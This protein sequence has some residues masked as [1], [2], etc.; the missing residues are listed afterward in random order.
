MAKSRRGSSEDILL[1]LVPLLAGATSL[2]L[3]VALCIVV[4]VMVAGKPVTAVLGEFE[5]PVGSSTRSPTATPTTRTPPP[6]PAPATRTPTA[7]PPPTIRTPAPAA[8]P[9]PTPADTTPPGQVTGLVVDP[10]GGSGEIQLTWDAS[11]EPDVDHY[12]IYRSTTEGGPYETLYN[13]V[14][15]DQDPALPERIRGFLDSPAWDQYCYVVSAV[16]PSGTEG[17]LSDE[18]CSPSPDTPTP[19]PPAIIE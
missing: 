4:T 9:P 12:N 15:N 18:A 6:T 11:P 19:T 7:T 14:S 2:A 13:T 8:T 1:L 5:P 16:D 3:A 10:G 17:Q